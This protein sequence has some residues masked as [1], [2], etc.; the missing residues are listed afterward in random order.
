[1]MTRC[2]S[3]ETNAKMSAVKI[4]CV[5]CLSDNVLTPFPTPAQKTLLDLSH[6]YCQGAVKYC[7]VVF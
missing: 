6:Q 5:N 2:L 4:S 7:E 3:L 1:M